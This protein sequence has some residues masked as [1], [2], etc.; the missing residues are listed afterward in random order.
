MILKLNFSSFI[1]LQV[2]TIAL[3]Q[4]LLGNLARKIN[5]HNPAELL[6]YDLSVLLFLYQS[7]IF[8]PEFFAHWDNHFA[9]G[10]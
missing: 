10:F 8:F 7:Q 2:S 5:E 9:A 1:L 6:A 4:L 3:G